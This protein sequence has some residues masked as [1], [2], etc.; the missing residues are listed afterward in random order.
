[1]L[2]YVGSPNRVPKYI[3]RLH[4]VLGRF[5]TARP[6]QVFISPPIVWITVNTPVDYIVA[7]TTCYDLHDSDSAWLR[8]I[9]IRSVPRGFTGAKTFTLACFHRTSS[10]VPRSR[11][12]QFLPTPAGNQTGTCTYVYMRKDF[13]L[14][15]C[16]DI[17]LH[18]MVRGG[19]KDARQSTL[20]LP[21]DEGPGH[22]GA[23][24]SL[25][26]GIKF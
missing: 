21:S 17:G 5:G 26:R 22:V 2:T 19:R 3:C 25:G 8:H 10:H 16:G 18:G 9:S 1:V 14:S 11:G 13:E 7:S 23:L 20:E 12:P 15:R 24:S 4:F 6:S